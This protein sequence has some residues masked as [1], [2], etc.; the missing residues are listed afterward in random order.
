MESAGMQDTYI[1][2]IRACPD[3]SEPKGWQEESDSE[4]TNGRKR[5][6]VENEDTQGKSFEFLL[7]N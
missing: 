6:R 1:K 7:I 2:R 3:D 4:L 5:R